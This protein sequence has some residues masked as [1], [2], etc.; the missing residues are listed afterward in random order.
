MKNDVEKIANQMI[1]ALLEDK[2]VNIDDSDHTASMINETTATFTMS[3]WEE[4]KT[5]PAKTHF[6]SRVKA[7]TTVIISFIIFY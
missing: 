6:E 3:R 5:K 2:N 4:N 1:N 7:I